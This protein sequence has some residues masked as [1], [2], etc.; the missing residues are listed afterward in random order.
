MVDPPDGKDGSED[1]YLNDLAQPACRH[2]TPMTRPQLAHR[3]GVF[4]QEEKWEVRQEGGTTGP[5]HGF[6]LLL[7]K[8]RRGAAV[9]VLTSNSL[10]DVDEAA[11]HIRALQEQRPQVKPYLGIDCT[12]LT[13]LLRG[14]VGAATLACVE[15]LGAGIVAVSPDAVLLLENVDDVDWHDKDFSHCF[16]CPACEGFVIDPFGYLL[17]RFGLAHAIKAVGAEEFQAMTG[18]DLNI[19][20]EAAERDQVGEPEE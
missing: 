8:G 7:R 14:D 1:L 2:G 11:R 17:F 19:S 3:I 6:D 20:V 16:G 4:F 10:R 13:S 15:E 9:T 18:V 5:E 12:Q